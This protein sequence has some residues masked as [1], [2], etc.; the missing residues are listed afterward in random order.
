MIFLAI[1]KNQTFYLIHTNFK[2]FFKNI[3]Y[4][5]NTFQN[6]IEPSLCKLIKTDDMKKITMNFTIK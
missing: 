1:K 4:L 2:Y 6:Q 3:F 5:Y